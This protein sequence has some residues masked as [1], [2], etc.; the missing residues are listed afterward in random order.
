ML[1][2]VNRAWCNAYP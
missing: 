2:S 1:E